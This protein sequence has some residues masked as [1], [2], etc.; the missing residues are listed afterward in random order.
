MEFAALAWGT[1]TL[2]LLIAELLTGTLYFYILAGGSGVT[3]LISYFFN[4]SVNKEVLIFSITSFV[5]FIV[6]Q[7]WSKKRNVPVQRVNNPGADFIGNE[8]TLTSAIKNG[9]GHLNIGDSPW[10]LLGDDMPEGSLVRVVG[11]D[12]GTLSVISEQNQQ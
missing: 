8:Y 2:V 4:P 1:L 10:V 7:W 12:K 11:C 3:A 5:I 6:G 9:R